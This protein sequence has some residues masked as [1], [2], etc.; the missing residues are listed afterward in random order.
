[1]FLL[2]LFAVYA[3]DGLM[4]LLTADHGKMFLSACLVGGTLCSSHHNSF[5]YCSRYSR[6]CNTC[7]VDVCA[8]LCDARFECVDD[9]IHM[10][11]D[12]T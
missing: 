12:D 7:A 6:Y 11:D 8:T 4:Y 2:V 1:M 9:V 5:A 10:V 3:S